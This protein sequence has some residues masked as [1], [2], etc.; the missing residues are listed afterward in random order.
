L[1]VVAQY[2]GPSCSNEQRHF[3]TAHTKTVGFLEYRTAD[4]QSESPR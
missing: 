1:S 3:K 4:S 2:K